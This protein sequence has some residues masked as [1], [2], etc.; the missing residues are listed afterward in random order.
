M[1][2]STMFTRKATKDEIRHAGRHGKVPITPVT[3]QIEI[4][5]ATK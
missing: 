2:E 3:R 5:E 1:T 4:T